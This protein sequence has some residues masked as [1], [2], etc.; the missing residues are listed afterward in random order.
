LGGTLRAY[1]KELPV[2]LSPKNMFLLSKYN[3]TVA[4]FLGFYKLAL[5]VNLAQ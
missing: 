1:N 2:L 3:E 4:Y 5:N